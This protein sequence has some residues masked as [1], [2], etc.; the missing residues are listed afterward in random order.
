M[1]K[2]A[3]RFGANV[4]ADAERREKQGSSYGY[5]KLPKG[6]NIFKET[7]GKIHVDIIPYM[8]TDPHH[9]DKDPE[10]PDGANPGNPWYKKPILVHRNVGAEK[11]SM[12]CP[13][14]AGKKCPICEERQKQQN[15][16]VDKKE[17]IDKVSLRNL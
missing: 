6:V 15:S 1:A 11:Q 10:H 7:P 13:R 17:M 14:T 9:M 5:L 12:I 4:T 16:G 3:S 2:R 8:V